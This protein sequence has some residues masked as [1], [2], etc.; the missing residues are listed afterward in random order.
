MLDLL[1]K[2][3]LPATLAAVIASLVV[4]VPL[5]FNLDERYAKRADFKEV[6]TKLEADNSNLRHELAQA[7]GFQQAMLALLQAGKVPTPTAF[8]ATTAPR[9]LY[10]VDTI[11]AMKVKPPE[12]AASAP[13]PSA[14]APTKG[15]KVLEKPQNWKELSEGLVRQQQRLMLKD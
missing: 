11:E 2:I 4:A 7:V 12:K 14:S 9:L 3:G 8:D 13:D 5:A 1:K 15:K 10:A 6:I